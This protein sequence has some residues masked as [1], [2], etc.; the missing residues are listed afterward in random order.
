MKNIRIFFMEG[1]HQHTRHKVSRKS[2]G[3]KLR[4]I[5]SIVC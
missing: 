2:A 3:D 1:I 4:Y 5:K